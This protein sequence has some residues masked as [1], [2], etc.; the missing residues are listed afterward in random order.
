[1]SIKI[2]QGKIFKVK[3]F[4]ELNEKLKYLR[5][6]MEEIKYKKVAKMTAELIA[7][8]IDRATLFGTV[9]S[10]YEK[11]EEV[12]DVFNYIRDLAPKHNASKSRLDS[13]W[14]LETSVSIFPLKSGKVIGILYTQDAIPALG[15]FFDKQAWVKD[16]H[17][18][19]SS[20]R[21]K[22]I[23]A[24]VWNQ[25]RKDWEEALR[26]S[27]NSQE[28]GVHAVLTSANLKYDAFNGWEKQ[29][30]SKQERADN[31]FGFYQE[32]LF[33]KS[34]EGQE[35]LKDM[36]HTNVYI[37]YIIPLQEFKE[38][39]KKKHRE[40]WDRDFVPKLMDITKDVLE[41][42]MEELKK[43]GI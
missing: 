29:I 8:I 9:S 5:N 16:Y 24:R 10:E 21:P 22:S 19:N 33:E 2:P 38:K 27:W 30:P 12:Y 25:R 11:F 28:A 15:R 31:M 39:N 1:M 26:P 14:D 34:P 4:Y 42:P 41:I 3:S 43:K 6:R 37:Q 35:C 40:D 17:Y 32:R 7:E 13:D 36:N 23:S 20:D 18:Q